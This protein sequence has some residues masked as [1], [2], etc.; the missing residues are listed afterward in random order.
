MAKNLEKVQRGGK[1]PQTAVDHESKQSGITREWKGPPV[2][3]PDE[4][5]IQILDYVARL[6]YAQTSLCSC[7]LLSRQWYSAAVPYLYAR[8]WISGKNFDQFYRTIVPSVNLHIR[9]S[10]LS[11]LVKMLDMSRLVHEGSKKTTARLLG[12][13]KVNLEYFVAPQASFG[14]TCFA[15]LSK[16]KH[17]KVLNLSFVSESPPLS[18]LFEHIAHLD[19]LKSLRLPRSAGFSK[20]PPSVPLPWPPKLE[21]LC[22]SGGID[23]HFLQGTV[24]FPQTLRS[25]T[26]EHCPGAKG[27]AILNLL[28]TAVRPL[29][30]LDTL[31]LSNLPRLSDHSLED[32]LLLLPGLRKLSISVDYITPAMFDLD[33]PKDVLGM[34]MQDLAPGSRHLLSTDN[35]CRLAIL[36]LTNSGNPGIEEKITPID[37]LIAVDEGTL[38]HLKQVRVARTLYWHQGANADDTD[39]LADRL[40]EVATLNGNS[41]ELETGVWTIDG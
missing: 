23:V 14:I 22:L 28:R 41:E 4:I 17:L 27:H 20:I 10:P 38:P 9:K 16:C 11:E 33:V 5:V 1:N 6:D 30:N 8:P 26:I 36:E 2:H 24:T 40:A 34:S 15:P 12:R 37:V 39:A 13:T 31:K 25:L 21:D 3:L 19:N 29:P 18:E 32:V 35:P 7:C